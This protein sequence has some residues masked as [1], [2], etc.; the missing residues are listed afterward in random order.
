MKTNNDLNLMGVMK[1]AL[2]VMLFGC[3]IYGW[4]NPA[5]KS[6]PSP[7]NGSPEHDYA[8]RRLKM[9][10]YSDREAKDGA[11]AIIKFQN[12]QRARKP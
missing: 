1:V 2:V 4:L 7:Y 11:D 3:V 9:E 8:A 5:P 6:R 10:G 12:A